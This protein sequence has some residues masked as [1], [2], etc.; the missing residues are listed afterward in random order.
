MTFVFSPVYLTRAFLTLKQFLENLEHPE[1]Q[2]KVTLISNFKCKKSQKVLAQNILTTAVKLCTED[3]LLHFGNEKVTI[4]PYYCEEEY[5]N[6][7][8][9]DNSVEIKVNQYITFSPYD[10][11]QF[12][13]NFTTNINNLPELSLNEDCFALFCPEIIFSRQ[14]TISK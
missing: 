5:F 7:S 4:F 9:Q 14:I 13:I 3:K 8:I 12:H 6:V 2:E 10:I 1:I 11:Q